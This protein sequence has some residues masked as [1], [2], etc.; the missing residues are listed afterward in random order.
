MDC[1]DGCRN[2][3]LK[4]LAEYFNLL[5]RLRL[6]SG[7]SSG[8]LFQRAM[9][10]DRSII[11]TAFLSSSVIFGCFTLAALL[12]PSTKYLYLGGWISIFF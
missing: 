12:A 5:F 6:L 10:V 11:M 9:D 2:F 4:D 7:I 8:P 1:N 3:G